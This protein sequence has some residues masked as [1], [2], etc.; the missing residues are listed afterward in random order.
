M[1]FVITKNAGLI[2]KGKLYKIKFT[3]SYGNVY[4]RLVDHPSVILDFF[5]VSNYID[6]HNQVRQFELALEKK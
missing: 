5:E 6:K 4:V 2:R 1:C 3:D